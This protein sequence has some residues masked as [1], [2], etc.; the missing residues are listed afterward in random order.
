M[1]EWIKKKVALGK[2]EVVKWIFTKAVNLVEK[3]E[4]LVWWEGDDCWKNQIP[5]TRLLI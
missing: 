3:K 2:R 5:L 4:K 1:V